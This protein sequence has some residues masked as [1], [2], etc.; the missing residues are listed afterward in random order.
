[1][2]EAY[3][4]APPIDLPTLFL[5][6]TQ[7]CLSAGQTADLALDRQF[8]SARYRLMEFS[9]TELHLNL[10]MPSAARA[11]NIA[12]CAVKHASTWL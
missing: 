11:F 8:M 1:M 6:I 3:G 2:A 12:H 4:P 9:S 5:Q 7:H 10:S